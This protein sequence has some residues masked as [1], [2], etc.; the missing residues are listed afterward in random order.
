MIG[1]LYLA[2][3]LGTNSGGSIVE[4][5]RSVLTGPRG[6]RNNNPGNIVR[7]RDSWKG[8]SKDQSADARFVVFDSPM[9]GLR[10]LARILRGYV[11]S[12]HS[13][14]AQI[15][16]RWAPTTENDTAAYV[17]AVSARLG[18]AP[19]APLVLTDS[20][21]ARLMAAIV[22]HENGQQPFSPEI[23]QQSIDLERSA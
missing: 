20:T 23:L 17:R 2:A 11:E 10:A 6:L 22:Q 13:S 8:M 16:A 9:W 14:V 3:R 12:G 21:L 18:V 7:T 15:I 5:V 19:N 4:S 1:L